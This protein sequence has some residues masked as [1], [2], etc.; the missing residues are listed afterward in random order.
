MASCAARSSRR[1]APR[2]LYRC[3]FYVSLALM[4]LCQFYFLFGSAVHRQLTQL[5]EQSYC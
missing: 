4:L 5:R 3:V 1:R 2:R